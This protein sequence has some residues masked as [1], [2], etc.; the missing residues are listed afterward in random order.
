MNPNRGI[1]PDQAHSERIISTFC[2]FAGLPM[3]D[4]FTRTEVAEIL[5]GCG[6]SLLRGD[7]CGIHPQT[8]HRRTGRGPLGAGAYSRTRGGARQSAPLAAYAE[9]TA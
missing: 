5:H 9:S 8:L 1:Q 7:D 3:R 4:F 6:Y 2:E